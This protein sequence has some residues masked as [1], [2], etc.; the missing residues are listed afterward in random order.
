MGTSYG[1]DGSLLRP[2]VPNISTAEHWLARLPCGLE[3]PMVVW[4][5]GGSNEGSGVCPIGRLVAYVN[6]D[7]A[8]L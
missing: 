5:S 2:L 1:N 6:G 3:F 4:H 7:T 8:L